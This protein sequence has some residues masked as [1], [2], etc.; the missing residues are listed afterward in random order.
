MSKRK[1]PEVGS[2]LI[3]FEDRQGGHRKRWEM[4]LEGDTGPCLMAPKEMKMEGGGTHLGS[5]FFTAFYPRYQ[6]KLEKVM[7]AAGS[8]LGI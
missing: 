5:L 2:K 3:V 6:G 7:A 8:P 4:R 1:V